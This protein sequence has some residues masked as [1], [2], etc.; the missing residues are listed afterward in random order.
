MSHPYSLIRD[1]EKRE[2][3]TVL[4]S[5]GPHVAT[6]EGHPRFDQI[7]AAV[8][9]N[10]ISEEELTAL[11]DQS[12]PIATE[13]QRVTERVTV[14]NGRVYFDGDE[15][16]G[17]IVEH[18]LRALE[19]D[20]NVTPYV[21]FLDKVEQNPEPHSREQL[22]DW[23]SARGFTLLPDGDFIGYKGVSSRNADDEYAYESSNSGT[24]IVDG[25]LYED[26]HIPN[27][28]GAIVEMPRSAVAHDPRQSCS[29][30]LH[31]G[32]FDYARSWAKAARLKVRISPRDVVSVPTGA[33]GQK[34]RVC[35]YT[36]LDV[37][38]EE[39]TRAIADDDEA[40]VE[41]VAAC[42]DPNCPSGES[43]CGNEDCDICH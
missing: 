18:I 26:E 19:E 28:I 23:L 17:T 5:D 42:G 31:V 4:L 11:F 38:N 24:A 39:D 32:T 10:G 37:A 43:C 9:D 40:E 16:H 7:K 2:V 15:V 25:L 21:A 13:F 36:V 8:E 6:N 14:S 33:S 1:T 12:I 35:R 30:G 34:M 27:D 22:Y 29:T 20:A 41:A 3:I